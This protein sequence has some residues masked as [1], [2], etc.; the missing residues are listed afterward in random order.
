MRGLKLRELSE[1][2]FCYLNKIIV[3]KHGIDAVLNDTT[4]NPPP[5]SLVNTLKNEMKAYPWVSAAEKIFLLTF[6]T[7]D[8]LTFQSVLDKPGRHL[9][10]NHFQSSPLN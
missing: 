7:L 2:C 6:V 10:V 9:Q 8:D 5:F 3:Y 4:F 1:P